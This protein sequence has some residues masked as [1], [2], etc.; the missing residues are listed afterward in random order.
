MCFTGSSRRTEN[1][2]DLDPVNELYFEQKIPV[3]PSLLNQKVQNPKEAA[4]FPSEIENILCHEVD[5]RRKDLLPV[6]E[7][8]NSIKSGRDDSQWPFI[9]TP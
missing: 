8:F 4:F 3:S 5:I 9:S 6:Y 1:L 7:Q 2:L